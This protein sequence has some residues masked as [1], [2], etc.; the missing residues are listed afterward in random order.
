MI[1]PSTEQEKVAHIDCVHQEEHFDRDQVASKIMNEKI[2]WPG[3]RNMIRERI[4]ICVPVCTTV[5]NVKI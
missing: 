4:N 5:S 3:F 1:S 2:R